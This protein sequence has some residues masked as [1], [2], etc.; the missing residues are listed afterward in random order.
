MIGQLEDK[1]KEDDTDVVTWLELISRIEAKDKT[2]LVRETYENFLKK[3]PFMAKQWINYI[4]YELNRGEFEKVE[5]IFKKCLYNVSSVSLW[6]TYVNY[7]RRKNNLITGG[8]E[9][10]R[11]IFQA[12]DVAISKVGIDPDSGELWNEYFAFIDDWKP[13]STWDGQ[14]KMDLKRKIFKKALQVPLNNLET[15]W[16]N[17]TTFENE[18]STT[19]ARKF[20]S[21]ISGT[22]MNSRSWYKEWSNITKGLLR[23]DD[24]IP[25]K[26]AYDPLQLKK[27]FTWISWEKSNKLELKDENL[28]LDRVEYVFKQAIQHLT[29]YPELWFEFANFYRENESNYSSLK[30]QELLNEAILVNP[31]SF[32]LNFKL[33]ELY[34]IENNP[35]LVG[36]RFSTLIENLTQLHDRKYNE[37][38][39]LKLEAIGEEENVNEDGETKTKT[40]E[41]KQHII[42]S[43]NE[44][45]EKLK[46]LAKLSKAISLTYCQYIK[47]AK[48]LS[49]IKEARVIF[50]L[51]RA[52][53]KILTHHVFV[54]VATLEHYSNN[55][56]TAIR[57]FDL[58]LKPNFFGN[59][60]EYIYKYLKFLIR[61]NDDTNLRSLFETTVN[62]KKNV[63]DEF[64]LKRIF[65]IYMNYELNF[66]QISSVDKLEKKYLE[67]F[68]KESKILLF[69]DR[70]SFKE[71]QDDE[72]DDD[73]LIRFNDL[74][75]SELVYGK[76]KSNKRKLN[77]VDD[78]VDGDDY[79]LDEEESNKKQR[80]G[81]IVDEDEHNNK[82]KQYVTDEVYNL[83]RVLPNNSYFPKPV[84]NNSKLISLLERTNV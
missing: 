14:Q 9:A 77:E 5:N 45:Q 18:L 79:D 52:S 31:L 66:G 29:F 59:D 74:K 21:E 30:V 23:S 57:V 40:D 10:R 1:L 83:L 73:D 19:T 20:I 43:N 61:I 12:Y 22:Y 8:E 62:T 65:K 2:E 82:I 24:Y 15:L 49:G 11:V 37:I 28:V 72:L 81:E 17:Y 53:K 44:I 35:I 4:M 76:T 33:I 38:E 48:R 69:A 75:N 63:I 68:P 16:G 60:G 56:K 6:R 46:E 26:G 3:F 84:F 34:E 47:S 13:V 7:I 58:G 70:Y 27:W 64:W 54:E 32:A 50:G 51:A 36:K 42:T 67:N 55:T 25:V 80:T 39:E 78:E 71:S 41:E